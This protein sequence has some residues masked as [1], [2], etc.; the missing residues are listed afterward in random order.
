[1]ACTASLNSKTLFILLMTCFSFLFLQFFF[2]LSSLSL[3]VRPTYA[4][5]LGNCIKR[6]IKMQQPVNFILPVRINVAEILF[7]SLTS[8]NLHTLFFILYYSVLLHSCQMYV[9]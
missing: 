8:I 2:A 9:K 1:M 7:Y 5:R 6:Y 3:S 4:K